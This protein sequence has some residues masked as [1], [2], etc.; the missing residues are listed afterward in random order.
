MR[1]LRTIIPMINTPMLSDLTTNPEFKVFYDTVMARGTVGR[2][3]EP[4]DVGCAVKWRLSDE[5]TFINGAAICVDGGYTA[6]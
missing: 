5:A 2:I 4:E 1:N 3:G 6:R